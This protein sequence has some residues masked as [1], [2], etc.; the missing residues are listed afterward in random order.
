MANFVH[1]CHSAALGVNNSMTQMYAA[2]A[3]CPMLFVFSSHQRSVTPLTLRTFFLNPRLLTFCVMFGKG[4][5]DSTE[6]DHFLPSERQRSPR[7]NS[8][9]KAHQQWS[10]GVVFHATMMLIYTTISVVVIRW[11][12][13]QCTESSQSEKTPHLVFLKS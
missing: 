10:R 6:E 5:L 3:A 8:N 4:G 7:L 1:R 12:R 11:N 2:V 9:Q 13:K